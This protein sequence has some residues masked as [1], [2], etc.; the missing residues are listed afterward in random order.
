L[1]LL[2]DAVFGPEHFRA[3]IV[4][5]RH[6]ARSTARRWPR[7]HDVLL[8][9]SKTD[10]YAFHPPKVPGDIARTPHTLVLGR[11]G[12]KHQTFE[13]TGPGITREGE[14]G[15][16]WR[17]FDPAKLGRHWANSAATREEWDRARLIHW[18]KQGGWPRRLD[19]EPFVPEARTITVGD[20]WTD[21][22]RINQTAKE[23]LGYPTQKPEALL[24][25]IIQASSTEGDVVLDP[26]CGCGTA[27]AVAERLKRRWVGIDITYVAVTL[28]KHRLRAT[29]QD[30]ARFTVVGEPVSF[31]DARALAAQDRMQFQYW[32]LGLVGARPAEQKK[33]A[34]KGI[35][36]RIYFHDEANVPSKQIVLSVKSGK[37]GVRDVRDL[38]GVIERENAQIGVLI[39]LRAPTR[40][41]IREAADAGFYKSQGDRRYAKLQIL[42]IARLL[43]GERID[44]PYSR[45]VNVSLKSAPK[46]K[47]KPPENGRLPL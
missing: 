21:I 27:I 41:M 7:V 9:Y 47:P 20:V 2:L 6:N 44:G 32:A 42:T 30:K 43:E 12:I 46:I 1:K 28:V 16:P 5:K 4:W 29:F 26:F 13:L 39:T 11:D 24:E 22:D 40:E 3:E 14:S 15:K 31:P 45:G 25:R 17:G 36:G 33:G 23:R 19:P 18:P 37:V 35:D 38:R 34:D 8:M 10:R